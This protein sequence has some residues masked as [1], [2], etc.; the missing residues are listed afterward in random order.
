MTKYLITL[1]LL[2][3]P[4]V[5][6]GEESQ[7]KV[8]KNCHFTKKTQVYDLIEYPYY[9]LITTGKITDKTSISNC[10]DKEKLSVYLR[11]KLI[12]RLGGDYDFKKYVK[13]IDTIQ[14]SSCSTITSKKSPGSRL[15]VV[16]T[17]VNP[18]LDNWYKPKHTSVLKNTE[19]T[20][21]LLTDCMYLQDKSFCSVSNVCDYNKDGDL[22]VII[23]QGYAS[24]GDTRIACTVNGCKHFSGGRIH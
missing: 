16:E 1:C 17:I 10:P 20:Y 13:D 19:G 9:T 3:I 24:G 8:N 7:Y 5:G 15:I 2:S 12:E 4:L 11:Q 23:Y 6:V 21:N 14:I 22:D 18:N